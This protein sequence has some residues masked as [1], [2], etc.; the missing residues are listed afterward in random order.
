MTGFG[1][2]SPTPTVSEQWAL[3]AQ[4]SYTKMFIQGVYKS[5]LTN[6]QD[7]KMQVKIIVSM[8]TRGLPYAQCTEIAWSAKITLP[9]IK[10][11]ENIN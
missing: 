1:G 10:F 11:S 8:F 2:C 5:S 3:K 6:L 9:I 7:I 4:W